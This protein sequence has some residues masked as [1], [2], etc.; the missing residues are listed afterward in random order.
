[1]KDGLKKIYDSIHGFIYLNQLETEFVHSKAFQ[2]LHH[3]HQLGI[4]YLVYPG[5]THRR[6]DHSLGVMQL[7]SEMYD[8]LLTSTFEM[9]ASITLQ[10]L[11]HQHIPKVLTPAYEYY[12]QIVRL[13]ALCHDL[14]HLPFSHAAEKALIGEVG[15]ETWTVKIISSDH[16]KPFWEEL[17]KQYPFKTA[18]DVEKDVIKT[19]VGECK[20]KQ[21]G[22]KYPF[23]PWEKIVSE[24]ITA[25]FFGADRIDYLIRDAKYTGIAY[26]F[27]DYHQLIEMLRIIPVSTKEGGVRLVLGIEEDGVQSCEALLMSRYFMHKRICHYATVKAYNWHVK[28][29]MEITYKDHP[30]LKEIDA[31]IDMTENE[32]M[33]D[34]KTIAKQP[35]HPAYKEAL[36][37]LEHDH[38][39][40]AIPLESPVNQE[41]LKSA[42]KALNTS[43]L[44]VSWEFNT[45]DEDFEV[46]LDF[47]V[48]KKE[49]TIVSCSELSKITVPIASSSWAYVPASCEMQFRQLLGAS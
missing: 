28:K 11:I 48:L 7:A 20:L 30:F 35:S 46:G 42:I 29:F 5:G 44:L 41:K 38:R 33:V 34:I 8:Q 32:V 25:D 23:T 40:K 37:I 22:I 2:R 45:F 10:N 12:R 21:M 18:E 13:S 1:M 15:H 14:G 6:F 31:Y 4:A 17:S 27:F 49:G 16:L 47:P 26:G 36:S 3:I 19:A 43:E 24:I 39:C 9:S